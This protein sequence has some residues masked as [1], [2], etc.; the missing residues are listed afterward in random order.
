MKTIGAK[1]KQRAALALLAKT[2]ILKSNYAPPYLLLCWRLGL[3]IPPPHFAGFWQNTV[4][5]GGFYSIA[6]GLFM[7]WLVWSKNGLPLTAMLSSSLVAGI[8]FG[9]ALAS[10][11]AYG[12]RKH[13]LPAWRDFKPH[14]VT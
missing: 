11:F 1:E 14:L 13:G 4:F 9:L 8:L 12:K 3:D 5:S 10:Y 6:W 7:Y 2:G